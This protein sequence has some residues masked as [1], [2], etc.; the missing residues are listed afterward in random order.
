MSQSDLNCSLK[1]GRGHHAVFTYCT[2]SARW[3]WGQIRQERK[4]LHQGRSSTHLFLCSFLHSSHWIWYGTLGKENIKHQIISFCFCC[5]SQA[6]H[7]LLEAN[8]SFKLYGRDVKISSKWPDTLHAKINAFVPKEMSCIS[9]SPHE[10]R[11]ITLYFI[12]ECKLVQRLH[13]RSNGA[14]LPSLQF[15]V[16][17]FTI[18]LL[19]TEGFNGNAYI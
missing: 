17:L 15:L 19:N 7:H 1:L 9:P 6:T 13:N 3:G 14:F 10:E 12:C 5:G 4:A 11:N 16:S 2:F 18:K 8:Q